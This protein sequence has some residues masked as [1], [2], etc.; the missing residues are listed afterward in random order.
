MLLARVRRTI[1]ERRLFPHDAR[2]VVACSGGPD[3]AVLLDV[4]VRLRAQLGLTLVAASVDHGLREG[5]AADGEVARVLAERLGVPFRAL[6]VDVARDAASLQASARAARYAALL[7]LAREEGARFV[8]VGHTREDQAETVLARLLRGA[9]IRGLAGIAPRRADGV[10]RPL[11]DCARAAVHA[12]AEREELPFVRDPS[13]DDPRFLRVRVR[14]DLLPRLVYEDPSAAR[15]LV[16][17]ADEARATSALVSRRA[18][19]A[20]ARSGASLA[21]LAALDAPTRGAA[22]RAH[23]RAHG[24][25]AARA[26]LDALEQLVVSGRGEVRLPGGR[27]AVCGPD[28]DLTIR[29]AVPLQEREADPTLRDEAADS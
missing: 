26:H 28:G 10:V 15:H 8:A 2:I 27:L 13:N 6:R 20:L 25:V 11:Y 17:L 24:I 29:T 19:R 7:A 22:L 9:G 12:W 18:R 23:L 4:L 16:A 5:A 3:S 14:R 21:G 1:A